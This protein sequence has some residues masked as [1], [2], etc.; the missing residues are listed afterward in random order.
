MRSIP[1]IVLLLLCM[2]FVPSTRAE[3]PATQPFAL[4]VPPRDPEMDRLLEQRD[5]A[6]QKLDELLRSRPFD[7]KLRPVPSDQKP[8]GPIEHWSGPNR[9]AL[10]HITPNV[11]EAS[12][13]RY[14]LHRDTP[15]VIPESFKFI[16]PLRDQLG[17]YYLVH[18]RAT[19]VDL[20]DDRPKQK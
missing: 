18:R 17:A 7:L 8:Q 16:D 9:P 5:K 4:Y 14:V 10:F 20:I 3:T 1:F 15:H 11:V 13:G 19:D 12:P 6:Q 2:S